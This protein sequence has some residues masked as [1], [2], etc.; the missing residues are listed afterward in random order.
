MY[1]SDITTQTTDKWEI[2]HKNIKTK[3]KTKS[4]IDHQLLETPA[5]S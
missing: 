2:K 1:E 5:G 4:A 3:H